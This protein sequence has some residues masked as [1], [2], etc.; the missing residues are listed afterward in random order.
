MAKPDLGIKR[1]SKLKSMGITHADLQEIAQRMSASGFPFS[2]GSFASRANGES[3]SEAVLRHAQDILNE[4]S[5]GHQKTV[6]ELDEPVAA[7]NEGQ[8]H[9]AR[10]VIEID[11]TSEALAG[12]LRQL[13]LTMSGPKHTIRGPATTTSRPGNRAGQR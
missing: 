3:R 9:T 4:R 8:L 13:N 1:T 6:I 10:I 2:N 11:L 5:K 7:T 12:L